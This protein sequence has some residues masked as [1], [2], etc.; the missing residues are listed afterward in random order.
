MP[1]SDTITDT[2]ITNEYSVEANLVGSNLDPERVTDILGVEPSKSGLEGQPRPTS[3]NGG[4]HNQ[5]FWTLERSSGDSANECKDYQLNCL[6]DIVEPKITELRNA[7]V[8]NVYFYFTLC[9]SIGLLNIKF[10]AETMTRLSGLNADLYVSCFDC[11]DPKHPYWQ[12]GADKS[13][14]GN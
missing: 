1:E 2:F 14:T 6:L 10:N 3:S 4:T 5:N 11:F 8:E 7:G 13:S 9:S 12:N